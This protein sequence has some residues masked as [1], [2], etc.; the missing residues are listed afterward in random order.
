MLAKLTKYEFKATG[1]M[2]L[3]FYA[4]LLVL[5]VLN[6]I[7]TSFGWFENSNSALSA[8][9]LLL[10]WMLYGTCIAVVSVMTVVMIVQRFYKNLTQSEGYLMHVLPV[11]TWQHIAGKLIPAL[12]W[13]VASLVMVILSVLIVSGGWSEFFRGIGSSI[14]SV[15][16]DYGAGTV[17]IIAI[18]LILLG[19]AGIAGIILKFYAAMAIGQLSDNH[20]LI[21]SVGAYIGIEIA[22]SFVES[23][24]LF[25]LTHLI[26]NV[27]IDL[28]D[29]GNTTFMSMGLLLLY[30]I[31]N[32]AVYYIIAEVLLRKHLNLQ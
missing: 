12:V 24:G 28:S 4:A 29:I 2:M 3:L 18:L 10:T 13:S 32:A 6:K 21:A 26:T 1:R 17:F 9:P 27:N 30:A 15:V 19:I 22:E 31:I 7:N 20:K 5:T 11:K 16:A 25:I 8:L 14:Q 23:I